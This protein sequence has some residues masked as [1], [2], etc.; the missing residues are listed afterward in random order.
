MNSS[1]TLERLLSLRL[2]KFE[3][4]FCLGLQGHS[5]TPAQQVTLEKIINRYSHVFG[6]QEGNPH[7]LRTNN[8]SG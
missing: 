3:F 5:P 6:S 1:T 8:D 2:T 7:A 4:G